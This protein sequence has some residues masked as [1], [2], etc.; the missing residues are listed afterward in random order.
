VR[1]THWHHSADFIQCAVLAVKVIKA[2]LSYRASAR[3]CSSS[4]QS[5]IWNVFTISWFVYSLVNGKEQFDNRE[6]TK[7]EQVL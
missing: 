5:A 2:R 7:A 3:G 4:D 1:N 6:L